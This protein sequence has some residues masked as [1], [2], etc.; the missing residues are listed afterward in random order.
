MRARFAVGIVTLA[1]VFATVEAGE[2]PYEKY[3]KPGPEHKMLAKGVGAWKAH[4]K[5]WMEPGKAPEE[6]DGIMKKKMI[7]G[8]RFLQEDFVGNFGDEKFTGAGLMG[9]DLQKKKYVSNWIDSMSTAIMHSEGDYDPE[10]KTF[11][12]QSKQFNPMT[13]KEVQGREVLRIVSDNDEVFEMFWLMP[14][15]EFK[16]M[17]ITYTRTEEKKKEKDKK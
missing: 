9:Y 13:G 1:G 16:V 5:F 10:S 6:S 8:G 2:N 17:E 7:M 4:V 15:G 12:F 3:S 14:K 11:T